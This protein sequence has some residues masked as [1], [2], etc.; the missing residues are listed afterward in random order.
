[1]RAMKSSWPGGDVEDGLADSAL[2]GA[3]Q[4]LVELFVG[5]GAA[6]GDDEGIRPAVVPEHLGEGFV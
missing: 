5:E 1:M 6:G 2:F 4:V 3:L